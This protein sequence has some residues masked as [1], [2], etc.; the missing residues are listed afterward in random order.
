MRTRNAIAAG[1]VALLCAGS[2]AGCGDDEET[3]AASTGATTAAAVAN[4][5]S[6]DD[7]K[8]P[9]GIA[10]VSASLPG[11]KLLD[12]FRGGA[13]AAARK[14]NAEGGFGGRK[15][16][17]DSCN[18]QFQTAVAST[19]ARKTIAKDPV[20]M[21]GCEFS[22]TAAGIPV[23]AR[24]KTPS[25]NCLNST[26][27]LT[28][29][30]NFGL[31]PSDQGQQR[32][33]AVWLC[34]K[35][36]VKTVG[37]LKP[38]M[39]AM[40]AGTEPAAKML[41]ECGKTVID[42]VYYPLAAVDSTPYVSKVLKGKPDFLVTS[43]SGPQMVSMLKVLGKSGFPATKLIVPD[44]QFD[45]DTSLGLVGDLLDGAYAA[46]QFTPW[47]DAEDPQVAEYLEAMKGSK[48]EARNATAQWGYALTMWTYV[49]AEK[50]GFDAFDGESL[51][52]F[53]GTENGVAIPLSRSLVNPGPEGLPQ[54]KQ[55]FAKISQYKGD[56]VFETVAGGDD[57]WFN[58]FAP[59]GG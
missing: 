17:I 1:M 41:R 44:V 50:I 27:D 30:W 55:P 3:S 43:G 40:R 5:G 32:A 21:I 12:E 48:Q 23:Y 26:E 51:A 8:P 20:A 14:I 46:S 45:Y 24:A 54:L 22:W 42:P 11:V 59:A 19:C 15:V 9:V 28:S 29:P 2:I 39:P 58:G 33:S 49:A 6:I 36:D 57:G 34:A 53:A 18:S 47:G 16:V 13:E 38:D 37:F 56:G 4:A 10:V 25:F 52:K 31:T 7:G 35:P